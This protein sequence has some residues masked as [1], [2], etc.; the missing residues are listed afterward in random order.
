MNADYARKGATTRAKPALRLI[1]VES[2]KKAKMLATYCKS[3]YDVVASYGHVRTLPSKAASVQPANDFSMTW[4]TSD[5]ASAIVDKAKNAQSVILATD[6]DREGESIGYHIAEILK[7]NKITVPISRVRFHSLERSTITTSLQESEALNQD[8]V[9]A[10]FARLGIDYLVGFNISPILWRKIPGNRSAGRVQSVGLRLIIDREREIALFQPQDY[11][12][13]AVRTQVCTSEVE[14][15]VK[16][17]GEDVVGQFF[18]NSRQHAD[19]IAGEIKQA[20]WSIGDITTKR[21]KQ[22]PYAPFTTGGLQQEASTKLDFRPYE[23]MRLAQELYE[24]VNIDGESTGLITYMRTDSVTVHPDAIKQCRALITKN[25]GEQY[26][27]AAPRMYRSKGKNT[28]DAH[29][30]IRPTNYN[31]HPAKAAQYLEPKLA[32]L[33]R[34]IWNRAVASQMSDAIILNTSIQAVASCGIL[35]AK[36]SRCEFDGYRAVYGADE[37]DSNIPNLQTGQPVEIMDATVE[38][39]KTQPPKRY[40]EAGLIKELESEGIGRPSTYDK[41]ISVLQ[42]LG[43]VYRKNKSLIPEDRGWIVCAFLE[44]WFTQYVANEFTANLETKLDKIAQGESAWKSV[45]QEFWSNFNQFVTNAQELSPAQVQNALQ[46]RV[47]KFLIKETE[48]PKCGAQP[49]VKYSKYGGFIGCEGYPGCKWARPLT[50][51]QR[52]I[53]KD[54]HDTVVLKSGQ[55]GLY[56]HWENSGKMLAIPSNIKEEKATWELI[57]RWAVL[58]KALGSHDG[59]EISVEIGRF[60]VYIKKAARNKEEAHEYRSVPASVDLEAITLENAIEMLAI[61]KRPRP[62][63]TKSDTKE[64]NKTT[65]KPRKVRAKKADVKSKS[66]VSAKPKSSKSA[67]SS[68]T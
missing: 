65:A 13:I 43:Y 16:Q 56:A 19:A 14:F 55:Y 58:P 22:S 61:P 44:E 47:G 1:V 57:Q 12:T 27:P 54:E 20:K 2:P 62:V 51:N 25:W 10:C 29:E 17:W 7:E 35:E 30:A 45:L 48:C 37:A 15:E 18:Y 49:I 23:T 66:T 11:W 4:I 59:H 64:A 36:G 39:H 6:P 46:N 52:I 40:S 26:C 24:G 67:Q 53:H 38:D 60:G 9:D 31:I 41:I 63:R 21:R 34:I 42:S 8:L 28:Q 32:K 3:E 33:Y 68:T 5:R 50:K